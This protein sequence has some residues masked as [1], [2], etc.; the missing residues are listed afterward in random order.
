MYKKLFTL[1]K[2]LIPRISDTEL[3]A[4]KSGTTSLDRDIFLGNVK[5]PKYDVITKKMINQEVE[6]LLEMYGNNQEYNIV[7]VIPNEEILL[8]ELIKKEILSENISE[9]IYTN[10]KVKAF[11][12]KFISDYCDKYQ[13]KKYEIPQRILLVPDFITG[14][15]YITPK[16][17]LKKE[18]IFQRL[19]SEIERTYQLEK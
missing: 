19:E 15:Q 8:E 2:K 1:T 6:E 12:E 10:F 4:L 5:Y 11:L 14:T 13:V 3:I 7:I 9:D 16:L 18:K 17:S